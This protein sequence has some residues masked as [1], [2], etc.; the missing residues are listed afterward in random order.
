[1][2]G[3][4]TAKGKGKGG[5]CCRGFLAV[6]RSLGETIP[7]RLAFSPGAAERGKTWGAWYGEH[8]LGWSRACRTRCCPSLTRA[9]QEGR[10]GEER[11]AVS[12][13]D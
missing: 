8:A 11:K 10:G 9:G 5:Q 13:F 7:K 3:A 12:T 4:A 6:S 1:M 2:F